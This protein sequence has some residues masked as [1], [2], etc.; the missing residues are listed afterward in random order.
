MYTSGVFANAGNYKGFGDTK[1]IPG[2]PL[3]KFEEVVK[4]SDAYSKQPKLIMNLWEGC[5]SGI[6][7][8]TNKDSSLGFWDKVR[9]ICGN[10]SQI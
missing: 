3:E 6:Y 9:S 2:L 10:W 4:I 7:S 1:I 5:K 8:L